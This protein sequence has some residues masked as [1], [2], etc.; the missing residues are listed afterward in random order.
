MNTYQEWCFIRGSYGNTGD[1]TVGLK[2]FS[3]AYVIHS[4]CYVYFTIFYVNDN[5]AF[6]FRFPSGTVKQLGHY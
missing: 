1:K 6:V 5:V 2:Q 3:E 4:Q